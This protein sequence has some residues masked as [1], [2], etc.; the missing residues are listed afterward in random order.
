MTDCPHGNYPEE[1]CAA[2][3]VSDRAQPGEQWAKRYGPKLLLKQQEAD[4]NIRAKNVEQQRR[5]KAAADAR[6]DAIASQQQRLE[7]EQEA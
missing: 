5:R 1:R 2:C 7:Y 3:V 6:A 4:A